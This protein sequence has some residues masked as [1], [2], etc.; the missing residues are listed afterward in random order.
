[1]SKTLSVLNGNGYQEETQTTHLYGVKHM[2]LSS[3]DNYS[4]HLTDV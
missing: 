3:L 1:M 4:L 2:K